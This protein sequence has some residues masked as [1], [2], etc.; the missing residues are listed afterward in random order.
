LQW[1]LGIQ[2]EI[3]RGLVVDAAYVGNRGVWWTAPL[4]ETYAY[5][6]LTPQQVTAAGL[7]ASNL[8]LLNTPITSP[9]VQQAF[10]NLQIVMLPS[11]LQVVPSVYPGF[12]ATQV[13]GQALRAEPQ[14]DGIP[15]FLGPPLGDTWYDSLQV[16]VTK[17]YQRGLTANYAFTYQKELVSGAGADTS[18]LTPAAPRIND[19]E[20]YAQNKQLNQFD[21]PLVS[22][23][24]LTYQTPKMPGDSKGMK[25]AS[26]VTKDWTIAGLLRYQSGALIPTASSNNNYFNELQRGTNPFNNPAVWGGG[27]TFQNLVPGQSL[28]MP[29]ISPNCGCFDPTKQLVLN[30]AAFTDAPAGKFGT[31]PAYL[32]GYRWQRIPGESASLGRI[33]PLAKEGKINLQIRMEFTS[34][35]FNRTFYGAPSAGNPQSATFRTNNFM[36]GTPGALSLGYGFVNTTNGAGAQPRQGQIVARF[37]F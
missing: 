25:A 12:P 1:S 33:F 26:W 28:F 34:N 3:A 23:I 6:A 11:K 17:R 37:T 13:L 15:P 20:N 36:N 35:L 30:P 14:W 7:N 24:S 19:F 21:Y 4:L 2:R 9:L 22:I 16:K 29:G 32:N 8:T 5:N 18:Y 27:D 31:A 10:P